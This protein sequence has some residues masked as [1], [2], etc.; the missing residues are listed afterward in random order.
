MI[1]FVIGLLLFFGNH[2]VRLVMPAWRTRFIEQYG[3]NTWKAVYSLF[4]LAGLILLI[5]GF[6]QAR[7]HPVF[8]WYPPLWTHHIAWLLTWFAFVL[9]AAASIPAN[10]IKAKI[11]HPMYAGVKIWAFAHLVANGTVC[12]ILLFGAFLVWA[13]MGFGISRRRDKR[14]GSSYPAGTT[15]GTV[16]TL[17]A[18][19]IAWAVFAFYLHAMLIGVSPF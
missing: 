8:V 4:S 6:G 12:D 17:V 16:I 14:E 15:R 7:A 5:Y 9:L 11:G 18:G 2:S 1:Y 10:H 3:A 13:I 19:T